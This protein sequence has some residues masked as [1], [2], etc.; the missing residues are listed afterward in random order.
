MNPGE[1]VTAKVNARLLSSIPC[2]KLG[3]LFLFM[4]LHVQT[5]LQYLEGP[6]VGPAPILGML[7][8][9]CSTS[10]AQSWRGFRLK[11]SSGPSK[12]TT[13]C[14]WC[15]FYLPIY[16]FPILRFPTFLHKPAL[17][18]DCVNT[19]SIH[20]AVCSIGRWLRLV[21]PAPCAHALPVWVPGAHGA[22]C[23]AGPRCCHPTGA[24][25][26]SPLHLCLC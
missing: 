18:S 24:G 3:N 15:S 7:F 14:A 16:L 23:G 4:D 6:A 20:R 11:H 2:S 10:S 1:V 26:H 13:L 22:V 17:P 8:V 9:C 5:L 21:L 12:P 19:C 25:P